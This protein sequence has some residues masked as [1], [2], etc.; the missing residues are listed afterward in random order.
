MFLAS[1]TR[2]KERRMRCMGGVR[3]CLR[4]FLTMVNIRSSLSQIGIV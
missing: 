4:A 2:G 3:M 1:G